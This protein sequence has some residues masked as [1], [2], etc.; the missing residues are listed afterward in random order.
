LT[1][2]FPLPL[3]GVWGVCVSGPFDISKDLGALQGATKW[4]RWGWKIGRRLAAAGVRKRIEEQYD[5]DTAEAV[6]AAIAAGRN[7]KPI[8]ERAE[9]RKTEGAERDK[10]LTSPPPLH[11]SAAWATAQ[12]LARFLKGREGF[13]TPSSI[14]LG[15]FLEDGAHNPA[16]F[17]HWDGDGHLLTLAPTRSGKSVTTIIP[18]LLRYR[19][20]AIVLDPKGELYEATSAWRAAN[21]GPVYRI[22]PFDDGTDPKTRD[23]PKHGFNPLAR[24]RSQHHARGLAQLMFPR[25]PNGQEFFNDDAVS[26]LTGLILYVLDSAPEH[27]R[28]LGTVREATAASLDR[29]KHLVTLMA[30]SRLP[31]VRESAN[32]VLGKSGDRGLPNLR[33]TLHSKLSL[34]SDPALLEA[35]DRN[36]VDFAGLK[37]RPATVYLTVP[38]NL[39]EP[40]APFVKVVL[41]AALD[42]M[43]DNPVKPKIPVLFVLDEFLSL[44][45]FADFR[46]AIR[47]HASAGVRLWFFLQDM[48]TLEEHYPGTAWH[49]FL[50]TSV[51]QFFGIDDPFTAELVG[52]YLGNQTVAYRSTQAGGNV[53]A[54][55]GTWLED[56]SAGVSLST[57][58]SIQFL[59]RPLMTPDEL[60]ALLS[61][62]RSNGTRTGIVHIRG[63]R[64]FK[65]RLVPFDQSTTC[66]ARIG[67]YR[68][69]GK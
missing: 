65:V 42:A 62:W 20:S 58:E 59:G 6:A 16:G 64:A 14:L 28:N 35:T 60:M 49:A 9:R 8:L 4:A 18:N 48:G 32:N 53:S 66:L 29:F 50:N 25:D 37:D 44:G 47:T 69:G 57:G 22:A 40:Y 26:F 34:W 54:Q 19:G 30:A 61:D 7:P 41:K 33:D 46:N 1:R 13:D 12:D 27:R 68:G 23:F 51:K 11:G 2:C 17:V 67:A 24:I 36:D 55:M 21:V 39:L 52:R 3:A 63:P 56:G 45:P 5:A 38:L 43:L 15:T 31:G 10:L